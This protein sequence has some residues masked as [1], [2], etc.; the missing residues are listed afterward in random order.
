M[1]VILT[2]SVARMYWAIIYF[3]ALNELYNEGKYCALF[4]TT[5]I[6]LRFYN[7]YFGCN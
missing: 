4:C 2:C 1:C 5:K 7:I 6:K 3:L